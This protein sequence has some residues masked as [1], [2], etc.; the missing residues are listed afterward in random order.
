M[1]LL[2]KEGYHLVS[3]GV[4]ALCEE[5]KNFRKQQGVLFWDGEELV[6][7]QTCNIQLPSDFPDLVYISFDLDGLDPSVMPAVRTPVP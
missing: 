5:E 3:F 4:R 7:R 6:R 2:V 1:N